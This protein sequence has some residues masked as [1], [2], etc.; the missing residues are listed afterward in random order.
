M[1]DLPDWHSNVDIALQN[2]SELIVRLKYGSMQ[3]AEDSGAIAAGDYI[4]S[5]VM[6]KGII[7]GGYFASDDKKDAL[8]ILVDLEPSL[9]YS[10]EELNASNLIRNMNSIIYLSQYDTV[11]DSYVSA[12]SQ[13]ITFESSYSILLHKENAGN[14]AHGW[15][16][17]LI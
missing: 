8:G 11:N 12:I 10:F 17:T 6:G 7:Y 1:A 3:I 5:A 2:L 4:S 14:I 9:F 13:G 15:Y 16:H